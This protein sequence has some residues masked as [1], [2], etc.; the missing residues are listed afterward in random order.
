MSMVLDLIDYNTMHQQLYDY[1]EVTP[2]ETM[3]ADVNGIG[4]NR[5]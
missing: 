1:T 5:L 2:I 3:S 4:L